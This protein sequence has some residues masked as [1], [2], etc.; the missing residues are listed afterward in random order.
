MDKN[1]IKQIPKGWEVVS[2]GEIIRISSGKNLTQREMNLGGKFDVY[3]GNGITGKHDEYN[4]EEATIVL[5][6]VGYYCGSVHITSPKSW[7]TDN[8]FITSFPENLIDKK[9]LFSLLT[10]INLGQYSN[11][12][13]QPVISGKSIYPVKTLLP[14]LPEQL[15]IVDKIEE[16]FTQLDKGVEQLKAVQ[17]QLRTYRQAVLKAAFEGKLTED[18]RSAFASDLHSHF[19]EGGKASA[20]G[21]KTKVEGSHAGGVPPIGG[22]NVRG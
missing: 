17:Q 5:G 2:L 10:Y 15:R 22:R 12:T 21:E 1:E 18:W 9:F 16:L 20:D 8:A 13:A 7:V 11:S 4:V 6:R 19:G 14:P 3:G